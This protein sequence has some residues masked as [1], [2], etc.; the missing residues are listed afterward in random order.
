MSHR[1]ILAVLAVACAAG[2]QAAQ[3]SWNF[4]EARYAYVDADFVPERFNG[5]SAAATF[6]LTDRLHLRCDAGT[7]R[8]VDDDVAVGVAL[9]GESAGIALGLSLPVSAYASLYGRF[10]VDY[11]RASASLPASGRTV[12]V[13]EDGTGFDA[14]L[15]ARAVLTDRLEIQVAAV[16]DNVAGDTVADA[17]LSV[18]LGDAVGLTLGVA[19]SGD[20]RSVGVGLRVYW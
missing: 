2:A 5:F 9:E 18:R 20:L 16:H 14:E 13:S 8:F 6:A 7:A 15:G 4:V 12:T 10:R 11:T 19:G 3:P 1:R 17:T